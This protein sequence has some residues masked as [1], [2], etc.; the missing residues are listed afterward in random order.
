MQ[1]RKL[2]ITAAAG[3]TGMHTVRNLI[4]DG[5]AVRVLVH[6]DDARSDALR[7]MG[8]EIVIGD[9][10]VHDD[11]IRATQGVSAAYLCYPVRPGLI[12]ATAYFAD[13]ARRAGVGVVVNMSQISAREDSKSHAARDHWISER[14]LE[15]SD[16]PTINI[17]PTFFSDWM[18][19]PWV[20]DSIVNEGKI[21]FPYG[22]GRHAPISAEDQ[23]RVVAALL[24]QPRGHIGKTYRLYGAIERSQQ[25]VA[26]IVS[27]VLGRKVVYSPM[28]IDEYGDLLRNYGVHEFRIQHFLEVAIDYQNGLFAGTNDVVRKL[29]GRPP[30]TLE[31]FIAANRV[32]F[33]R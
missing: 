16:V 33:E 31:A 20:R 30:Q 32:A 21:T 1:H 9:L 22:S 29:T 23:G 19:Y 3:K 14:V 26:D 24:A 18:I 12:E 13:A 10:L 2:L 6:S 7:E 27:N 25:E 17:R 28:S 15:W 8:A 5:H 4:N 11:V